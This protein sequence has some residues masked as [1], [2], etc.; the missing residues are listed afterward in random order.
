MLRLAVLLLSSHAAATL[1]VQPGARMLRTAARPAL[2]VSMGEAS[3]KKP[4]EWK[5]VKGINDYGKEQTYMY[6]GAK[7]NSEDG[8][9]PLSKPLLS[10]AGIDLGS[11]SFLTAPYMVILFAPLAY[12][13]LAAVPWFAY[14]F[15]GIAL[16]PPPP[17]PDVSPIVDPVLGLAFKVI[18]TA[19]GLFM[20]TGFDIWCAR[21]RRLTPARR[22]YFAEVRLASRMCAGT[23]SPRP[24]AWAALC[25]GTEQDPQPRGSLT[26]RN[27]TSDASVHA[28]ALVAARLARE[29]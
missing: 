28:S 21:R 24:S 26:E 22:R 14:T 2:S 4:N 13:L 17:L 29:T 19:M 11:F 12:C 18:G 16:P 6:L 23:S 27:V 3:T 5:Y 25:C 9:S 20:K 1:Q 15:L 10:Y 8:S 7:D